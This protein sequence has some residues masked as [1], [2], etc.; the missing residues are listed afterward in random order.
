MAHVF[1]AQ[2]CRLELGQH[3]MGSCDQFGLGSLEAAARLFFPECYNARCLFFGRRSDRSQEYGG[4]EAGD[5]DAMV[6]F[7]TDTG[8]G[9]SMAYSLDRGRTFQWYSENPIVKH[10]GR[11]PKVLWYTYSASDSPLDEQA[12]KAGGHWVM[13]VYDERTGHDRNIA[14]Y[15]SNDL[16][17]WDLQSH[18]DG[19][20]ECPELFALPSPHA[21]EQRKWVI[22]AADGQYALG[23]FD[24]RRFQ[25]DHPGKHRLHYGNF[26]ASQTF[27][28]APN[29][30]RIQIGW[31]QGLEYPGMPFN[32][33]F[34]FPHELT[35][36][37]T[38]DGLRLQASPVVELQ[39]LALATKSVSKTQP[40]SQMIDEVPVSTDLLYIDVEFDLGEAAEVGVQLG[41]HEITYRR[42]EGKWQDVPAPAVDNRVQI[43]ILVD[44]SIVEFWAND[45][46][47]VKSGPRKGSEA[48]SSV[49]FF[50][51]GGKAKQMR[52]SINELKSIWDSS[53][54]K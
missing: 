43:K 54:T 11:D 20:Y 19:Y 3:D 26:Y 4:L 13:A 53:A 31:M 38:K 25:P 1:P 32:Q 45:G 40:S 22:F 10:Q 48:F 23:N 28:N 29:Q 35:L 12:K 5:R 24:G 49:K 27:E 14:F 7:L 30:R 21:S 18:L 50:S 33:A 9:E 34:S 52:A 39:T 44:R 46:L 36:K 41:E 16:K 8:A 51:R 15:T 37:E 47:V 2:S 6:V 17:K 42:S